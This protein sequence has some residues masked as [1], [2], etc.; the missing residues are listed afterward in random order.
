MEAPKDL[1]KVIRKECK[2]YEDLL[3]KIMYLRTRPYSRLSAIIMKSVDRPTLK[4]VCEIGP[5]NPTSEEGTLYEYVSKLGV[6]GKPKITVYRAS[7][8][9]IAP[10]D[11]VYLEENRAKDFAEYLGVRV[12]RKKVRPEDVVWA[13]TS[14]EEWFYVPK[15]LQGRWK[16]LKDFWKTVIE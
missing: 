15:E 4:R 12:F 9:P 14:P 5:I 7:K 13:G 10:G 6:C 8:E 2:N 11:W 3:D 16:S 1:V